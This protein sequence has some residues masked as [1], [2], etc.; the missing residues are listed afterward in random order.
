MTSPTLTA[1]EITFLNRAVPYIEQGMSIEGALRAVLARDQEITSISMAN[2]RTGNA[3]REGL[4]AETYYAIK[5][6]K[7]VHDAV[8]SAAD[9]NL[10]WR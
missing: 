4:A 2:T 1:A 5:G 6:R 9:S 3:I 10:N 7:A 8:N